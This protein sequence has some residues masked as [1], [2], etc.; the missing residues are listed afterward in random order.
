MSL[1]PANVIALLLFAVVI[2]GGLFAILIY[3]IG[4]YY[5]DRVAALEKAIN[6]LRSE[7]FFL[8]RISECSLMAF[9]F[10]D[11]TVTS[12]HLILQRLMK[13]AAIQPEVSDRFLEEYAKTKRSV[14]KWLQT[15]TI[16]SSRQDWRMSAL[17]QLSENLGGADTLIALVELQ[18]FERELT[19]DVARAIRDLEARIQAGLPN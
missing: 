16:Y 1:E 2:I 14:N 17:K 3:F 15:L 13:G 9:M 11:S 19:I 10:L 12:Q 7:E 4:R 8:S 18:K 5:A 6:G